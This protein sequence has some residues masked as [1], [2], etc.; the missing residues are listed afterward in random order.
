M[1]DALRIVGTLVLK[2]D[3][4][5]RGDAKLAAMIGAWLGWKLMLLSAFWACLLGSIIGLGGILLGL[6]GRRQPIPFGPYLVMG[7]IVSLFVGKPIL[8][9][10]MGLLGL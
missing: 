3:A 1:F 5:G 2:Q 9:W 8:A 10:Y 4:M 6:I 7:A